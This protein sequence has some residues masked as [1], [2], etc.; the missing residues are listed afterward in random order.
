MSNIESLFILYYFYSSRGKILLSRLIQ[1]N[2]NQNELLAQG[3][4][5]G[6]NAQI[7]PSSPGMDLATPLDCDYYRLCLLK[8]TTYVP[9]V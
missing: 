8:S 3:Q 2:F 9:G 1:L 4:T 7:F 6:E 5:N